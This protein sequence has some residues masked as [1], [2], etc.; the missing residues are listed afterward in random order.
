MDVS[1]EG[2]DRDVQNNF[3]FSAPPPPPAHTDSLRAFPTFSTVSSP[4]SFTCSVLPLGWEKGDRNL[5]SFL[6]FPPPETFVNESEVKN[7]S[8][9]QLFIVEGERKKVQKAGK[10]D[11]NTE[12]KLKV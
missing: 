5:N 10:R 6:S 8:P 2:T 9:S 7:S 1:K 11:T 12:M 4:H 3:R